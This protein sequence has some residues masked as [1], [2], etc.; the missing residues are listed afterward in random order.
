M[1]STYNDNTPVWIFE[2]LSTQSLF[3]DKKNKFE[4]YNFLAK[5]Y[6]YTQQDK[7]DINFCYKFVGIKRNLKNDKIIQKIINT[8]I[9]QHKQLYS[10]QNYVY[11]QT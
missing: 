3:L 11:G 4:K 5:L 7:K 10:L 6:F 1:F 2:Q 9:N 8:L